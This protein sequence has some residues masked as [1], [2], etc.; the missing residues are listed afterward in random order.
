MA[1]DTRTPDAE[2]VLLSLGDSIRAHR[3]SLAQ[4]QEAMA[5]AIDLDRTY[6]ASVESGKRNVSIV[7]LCKIATGLETTASELLLG[8]VWSDSR[9]E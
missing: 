2:R 7:N 8:V 9:G 5:H 3:K 6:Y 1:R 4:S